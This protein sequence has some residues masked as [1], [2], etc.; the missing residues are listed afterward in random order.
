MFLHLWK[1]PV[2]FKQEASLGTASVLHAYAAAMDGEEACICLYNISYQQFQL[3]LLDLESGFQSASL[4][5]EL[6]PSLVEEMTEAQ[7]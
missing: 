3:V 1:E 4:P 2:Q 5:T 7:P 6:R